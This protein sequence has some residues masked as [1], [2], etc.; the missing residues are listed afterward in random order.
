MRCEERYQMSPAVLLYSR[1]ELIR[2]GYAISF[3]DLDL[4]DIKLMKEFVAEL[5]Y[6]HPNCGM[7]L[8]VLRVLMSSDELAMTYALKD[9]NFE[10]HIHRQCTY[11]WRLTQD[12]IID[13]TM[14][15]PV[16]LSDHRNKFR[17]VQV[18]FNLAYNAVI[19]N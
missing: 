19:S 12:D 9:I 10:R 18:A 17:A 16:S 7:Y 8:V 14:H 5:Y 2:K 15:I 11:Q 1:M 4:C 13:R 6:R 3:H